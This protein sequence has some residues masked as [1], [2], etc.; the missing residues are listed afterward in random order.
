MSYDELW[1]LVVRNKGDYGRVP[2]IVFEDQQ[3]ARQGAETLS[4][5]NGAALFEVFEIK[6]KFD[7][8]VASFG[9][10]PEEPENVQQD[11]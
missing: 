3:D 8:P 7:N 6:V 11:D 1:Y 9:D 5:Q 2:I 10:Y 4:G